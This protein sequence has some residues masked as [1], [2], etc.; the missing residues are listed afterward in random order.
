MPHILG[1]QTH[2]VIHKSESHKLHQSFSIEYED[3][4]AGDNVFIGMPV[5]MAGDFLVEPLA[6]DDD[7]NLCIGVAIH[8][9][10]VEGYQDGLPPI[11]SMKDTYSLRKVTVAM[12]S[13]MIIEGIAHADNVVAGPVRARGY[14]TTAERFP[15]AGAV[16]FS[17]AAVDH[18]GFIGWALHDADEGETV[19]I[20]LC[21]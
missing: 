16:V 18:V 2:H 13:Y 19:R 6:H 5:K 4:G 12:R 21:I 14:D 17:T 1:D 3:K 7:A 15:H 20:A 9:T 10:D 11:N 8:D